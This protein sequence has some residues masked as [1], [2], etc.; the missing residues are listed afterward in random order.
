MEQWNKRQ[1]RKTLWDHR[2]VVASLPFGNVPPS[3]ARRPTRTSAR[4]PPPAAA[5]EPSSA[6]NAS[7]STP[8]RRPGWPRWPPAW[9]PVRPPW[10]KMIDCEAIWRRQ[11]CEDWVSCGADCCLRTCRSPHDFQTRDSE[12]ELVGKYADGLNTHAGPSQEE[13]T[14]GLGWTTSGRRARSPGPTTPLLEVTQTGTEGNLIRRQQHLRYRSEFFKKV[15]PN[16]V[17]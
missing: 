2:S 15:L 9:R 7:P 4:Q 11:P 12:F 6:P 5:E 1:S 3:P 10:I 13:W 8:P 14:L 17:Y 16:F